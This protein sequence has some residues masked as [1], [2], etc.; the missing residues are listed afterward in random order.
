MQRR[1][2]LKGIAAGAVLAGNPA[3]PAVLDRSQAKTSLD[4]ERLLAETRVPAIAVAGVIEGK[5]YQICTWMK[6]PDN[7]A[8]TTRTFFPAC[9]LSK[10]VFAW[11]VRELVR[12]GKLELS[13]P[14][15][16]YADLGLTGDAKLITVEHVL[17]HSS[18][19]PNW[20][21]QLG[22]P[23]VP[24]FTPGSRWRYSGE[25]IFLLQRVVEKIAG[26][27][28]ASFMKH[29]VL[30]P[31]GMT[32]STFAWAPDLQSRAVFGHDR[33]GQPLERSSVFYER[34]NYE[35]IHQ[36]GLNPETASYTQIVAAYQKAKATP[37]SI[38][39][40]PNM[41]GS[42]WT[43]AADYSNFLK[44]VLADAAARHDD[45]RPRIEVAPKIAWT[46]GLGVDLSFDQPSYFHWGDGPGF[47]NLAWVQPGR[48]TALV[49][50]TNG[51][52]GQQAYSAVL[53]KLLEIDPACLHWIT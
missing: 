27:P 13:K 40:A 9:S 28:I 11:G 35:A 8:I 52:N 3:L 34:K 39:I 31:L 19:L 44:H 29:T 4:L 37:L 18:G 49:L 5:E 45:Y 7:T 43:T 16:D 15:Q 6:A 25:G 42:L 36:A 32:A 12:K 23:L 22:Q 46:L 41:A 26:V 51:D 50:L 20:R 30:E 21:F 10:P 17:T 33:Q 47:K 48:K 1:A 53:Q 2:F 38:A 24:D 14:L